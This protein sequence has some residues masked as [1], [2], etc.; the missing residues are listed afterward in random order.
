VVPLA[1]AAI[2]ALAAMGIDRAVRP[3]WIMAVA[4][5]LC[6]DLF[7]QTQ[8]LQETVRFNLHPTPYDASV[9]RETK[10]ARSGLARGRVF[11]RK[12]WI[13]GYLNLLERR[14]DAWTAAPLT[15]AAYAA[16]YDSAMSQSSPAAIGAMSI[17]TILTAEDRR[18]AIYRNRAALPM[19]YVRADDGRVAPAAFAAFRTAAV[20]VNVDAPFDGTLILTQQDAPGWRASIDG[21][22]AQTFRAGVFRALRVARGHHEITWVYRP[23][24]LVAGACITLLALL[25]LLLS[26][27]FVKSLAR[28]KFFRASLKNA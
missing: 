21:R 11:D 3:R 25:R 28:E 6:V 16:A 17:G 1:A 9:G 7:I 19:A 26:S 23:A 2:C 15:S 24:S 10:F 8:P 18:V 5:I 4:A 14:F 13:A 12:A 20:F 22:D 27:K